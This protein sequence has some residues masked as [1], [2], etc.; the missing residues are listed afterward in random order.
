[1][2]SKIDIQAVT[3]SQVRAV[4]SG[5]RGCMCGCKGTYYYAPQHRA[6]AQ[7]E[8]GYAIGDDEISAAQ[9][10][11]I[12]RTIQATDATAGIEDFEGGCFYLE[13]GKRV[14]AVYLCD[15]AKAVV[16]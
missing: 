16:S 4:Y 12:L 15:A 14:F 1:M 10:T 6:E 2:N 11:R 7:A 9:V 13:D 3:P 8:R 5:R